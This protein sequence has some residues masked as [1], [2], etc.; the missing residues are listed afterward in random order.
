MW[1]DNGIWGM[2]DGK[3]VFDRDMVFKAILVQGYWIFT[4]Y[5]N[6]ETMKV[7]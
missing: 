2:Y 3:T 7:I 5:R 1:G 6:V 4:I